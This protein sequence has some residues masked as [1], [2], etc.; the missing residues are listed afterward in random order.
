M[1]PKEKMSCS[2]VRLIIGKES[3]LNW[4]T[5]EL[6]K[7]QIITTATRVQGVFQA[8]ARERE[9]HQAKLI[10]LVMHQVE[11]Q[12]EEEEMEEMII[13]E[14]MMNQT[15]IHNCQKEVKDCLDM[16]ED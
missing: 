2:E 4:N 5:L 8:A 11:D 1:Q 13:L 16:V 15:M 9:K 14:Q 7:D 3:Q 10:P 6:E 12:I